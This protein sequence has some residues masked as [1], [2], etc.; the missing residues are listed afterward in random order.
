MFLVHVEFMLRMYT[1][2]FLLIFQFS[3]QQFINWF[4]LICHSPLLSTDLDLFFS[5]IRKFWSRI[6]TRWVLPVLYLPSSWYWV[7]LVHHSSLFIRDLNLFFLLS[8]ISILQFINCFLIDSSFSSHIHGG[9]HR[10]F[11]IRS[12]LFIY[13]DLHLVQET[14]WLMSTFINIYFLC[15]CVYQS[16]QPSSTTASFFGNDIARI[17]WFYLI[18]IFRY[19]MYLPNNY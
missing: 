1:C 10:S 5:V 18:C 17:C 9:V 3:F 4:W 2:I 12:L 11:Y 6:S 19:L 13:L 15:R 7:S 14:S 8:E 16:I